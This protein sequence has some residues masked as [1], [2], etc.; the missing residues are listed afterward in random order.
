M[1]KWAAM[2]YSMQLQCL[3]RRGLKS[4]HPMPLD[5]AAVMKLAAELRQ[6]A[7]GKL[8][9]PPSWMI[10]FLQRRSKQSGTVHN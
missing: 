5:D 4:H 6:K 10:T 7:Q 3:K 2:D 1:G 8:K 9:I